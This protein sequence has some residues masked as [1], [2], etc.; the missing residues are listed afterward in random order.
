MVV[1][2]SDRI[3][4]GVET[5]AVLRVVRALE[6]EQPRVVTSVGGAYPLRSVVAGEVV[7]VD[8][9]ARERLDARP[10]PTCPGDLPLR[11]IIIE[12]LSHGVE[13]PERLAQCER[14]GIGRHA[15]GC[16]LDAE[17]EDRRHR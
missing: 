17:E 8:A 7:D 15:R 12:S 13:V 2:R 4:V 5:E 1:G 3:D 10:Q 6:G 9:P 14:G 11:V 16:A